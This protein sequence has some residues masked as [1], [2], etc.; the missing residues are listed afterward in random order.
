MTRAEEVALVVVDVALSCP[1]AGDLSLLASFLKRP[2]AVSFR[3]AATVLLERKA[4]LVNTH[5]TNRTAGALVRTEGNHFRPSPRTS[6]AGEAEAVSR[7]GFGV[8]YVQ[9]WRGCRRRFG[10]EG[11]VCSLPECVRARTQVHIIVPLTRRQLSIQKRTVALF[12]W[13]CDLLPIRPGP[14]RSRWFGLPLPMALPATRCS[15]RP[16]YAHPSSW[17]NVAATQVNRVPLLLIST[18]ACEATRKAALD[19]PLHDSQTCINP[20]CPARSSCQVTLNN[21]ISQHSFLG[22]FFLGVRCR[23]SA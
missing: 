10:R 5:S 2:E 1:R 22:S 6:W 3:S 9:A 19:E 14:P 18:Q 8:Y 16:L 17:E 12:S 7:R 11:K 15:S 13:S 23:S 20:G 21:H 4:L